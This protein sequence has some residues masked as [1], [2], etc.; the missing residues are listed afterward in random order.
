[1]LGWPNTF[2]MACVFLPDSIHGFDVTC[3]ATTPK[4]T[5]C[6][7]PCTL[8]GRKTL[9]LCVQVVKLQLQQLI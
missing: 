4:A 9:V 1:M 6:G 5:P 3:N 7:H 2:N 8:R